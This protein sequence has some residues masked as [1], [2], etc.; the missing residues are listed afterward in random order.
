MA[1]TQSNRGPSTRPLHIE[2]LKRVKLSFFHI[3]L[4]SIQTAEDSL[5]R[6]DTDSVPES[7]NSVKIRGLKC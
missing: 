3:V 2:C 1:R 4:K 5:G 6:R 7:N